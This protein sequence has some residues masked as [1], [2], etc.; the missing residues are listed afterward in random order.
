[1]S[2]DLP[3]N[4]RI[5][6]PGQEI[7]TSTSR[8]SGPGG[9]HAN[10]TSTRTTVSFNLETTSIFSPAQ[11]VRVLSKLRHRLTAEG[12][13]KISDDSTRSQKQNLE[14]ARARL[15]KLIADALIVPKSRVKTKPSKRA[16]ARR[17]DSKKKRGNKKKMRKKPSRDD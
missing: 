16:K 2:D 12:D 7:E 17:V 8:S 11:Q 4:R 10:K 14:K 15:A 1:M 13:L 6:I 3:I 5:T 9:Q